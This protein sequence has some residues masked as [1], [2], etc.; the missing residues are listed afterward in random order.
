M[1]QIARH[2]IGT[3][4]IQL[5]LAAIREPENATMFEKASHHTAY[6]NIF[7]QTLNSGAQ[8]ADAAHDQID[9]HACAR[10]LV[11]LLDNLEIGER[12]ELRNDACRPAGT[13]MFDLPI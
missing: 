11:K 4:D 7:R 2:P 12:V 10:G 1:L 5:I 9:L 6:A 3:A 8:Y 13:T